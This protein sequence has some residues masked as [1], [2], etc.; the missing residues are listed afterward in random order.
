MKIYIPT[1][2][3]VEGKTAYALKEAGIEHF[4]VAPTGEQRSDDKLLWCPFHGIRATRNYIMDYH[5]E[6]FPDDPK[7]VMLDD[8]MVF[9][10]RTEDGKRF[11]K[12]ESSM[13][14]ELMAHLDDM[15]NS[16]AHGGIVEKF[17]SQA[18]PR[19]YRENGRYTHLN[20]YNLSLFQ[21]KDHE[22]KCRMEAE[23]GEEQDLNIHLLTMGRPSFQ[24]T[25]WT[26]TD[27]QYA[28]GGCSAWRTD[29]VE[30]AAGHF[31][32]KKYPGIVKLMQPE[33][34]KPRVRISWSTAA[35]RGGLR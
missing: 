9:W 26:W 22:D 29:E 6:N 34:K 18:Q 3:R 2:D 17:M 14:P 30:I 12:C 1:R 20:A 28:P 13:L 15:L 11:L 24:L 4:V 27:K 8:D 32:E 16:Y 33:G 5:Q 7:L 21:C 35:A 25:E 10:A 19:H 31:L 23:V